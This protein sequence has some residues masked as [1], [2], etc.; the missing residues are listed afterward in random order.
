MLKKLPVILIVSVVIAVLLNPI[1]SLQVKQ[2]IF[3][4]SLTIKSIVLFLLPI[5]IFG[6]LFKTFVKLSENAM[7]VIL[8]IFGTL[9][10][11]NFINTFITRYLGEFLYHS[12]IDFS[13]GLQQ[14]NPLVP[15]FSF[16]L[17][18]LLK[19][20]H[21]LFCGMISGWILAV[22]NR[23]LALKLSK[24]IDVCIGKLFAIVSALIPLFII[25]FV[26]KCVAE[27]TLLSILK[28]YSQIL[29]LFIL[30]SSAYTFGFYLIANKFNFSNTITNF[31]NMMPAFITGVS[32]IS[33]ALTMPVTIVCAEKSVH[34][35]ELADSV[36]PATV[37]IHLLGDCIAI[38][39]LAFALLKHY[40]I[41]APTLSEYFIF[42][43][44]F[45]LAKFS[46]AAVPA[47]GVII[48]APILEKYLSFTP[49]MSTLLITIYV[50]FDPIVTGFNVMGNGALAKIIDN[51]SLSLTEFGKTKK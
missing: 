42:T 35:K 12:S 20:E 33:S 38:P 1:I 29:I 39:L 30:Y 28:G 25:G 19:N 9:I 17:P 49:E 34:N 45:V 27:G 37:N 51:L 32:T 18:C 48:M 15:Y 36:I 10:C 46:V 7:K 40:E 23:T 8:L 24:T 2:I 41:P 3:A 16:E 50:I 5:I 22:F 14:I 44:F 26:I 47:G 31:K 4:V 43:C 13:S 21:S 11:S 6:L